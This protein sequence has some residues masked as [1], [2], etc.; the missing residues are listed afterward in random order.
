MHKS[1]TNIDREHNHESI[2]ITSRDITFFN[3]THR[4]EQIHIFDTESS[5]RLAYVSES[6]RFATA[7]NITHFN[8]TLH[9]STTATTVKIFIITTLLNILQKIVI[10]SKHSNLKNK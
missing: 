10:A 1:P 4:Y 3:Q 5:N 9:A 7:I 6:I 8:A 2:N